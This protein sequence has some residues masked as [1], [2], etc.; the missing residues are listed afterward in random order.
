MSIPFENGRPPSI[1]LYHASNDAFN[2]VDNL[3]IIFYL[4]LSHV[5]WST[6]WCLNVI[7]RELYDY[8]PGE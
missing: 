4:T 2:V 8:G 6:S 5:G 3:D 7:A 1:P